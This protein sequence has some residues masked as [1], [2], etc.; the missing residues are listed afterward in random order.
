MSNYA[1]SSNSYQPRLSPAPQDRASS[2]DSKIVSGIIM[3][4]TYFEAKGRLD[5]TRE[6]EPTSTAI[7]IA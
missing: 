4:A 6:G 2:R 7:H 5:H 3:D 1:L